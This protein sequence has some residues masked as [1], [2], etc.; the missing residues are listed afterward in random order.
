MLYYNPI[1]RLQIEMYT[2]TMDDW[3]KE[4]IEEILDFK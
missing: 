4:D 1:E 2:A 3:A